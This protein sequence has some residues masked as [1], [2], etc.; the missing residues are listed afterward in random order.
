MWS[1][2]VTESESDLNSTYF[3]NVRVSVCP[4]EC[5]E[6]IVVPIEQQLLNCFRDSQWCA[7]LAHHDADKELHST[8]EEPRRVTD[9]LGR[10]MKL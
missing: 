6:R 8:G 1:T 10:R 7:I 5:Q 3:G 4:D 2:S 9:G